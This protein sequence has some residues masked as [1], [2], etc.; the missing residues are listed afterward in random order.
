MVSLR[1]SVWILFLFLCPC[2]EASSA[3]ETV[4]AVQQLIEQGDLKGA[5]NQLTRAL[6]QYPAE[7]GLHNLLGVAEAQLGNYQLAESSFLRAIQLAPGASGTYLNLGRLYQ[8]NSTR[9]GQAPRKALETYRGLLKYHP[10]DVEGNYQCA[11]LLQQQGDL[12]A[13]LDHLA[14]LSAAD[15]QRAQALAVRCADYAALGDFS[16]AT[17]AASRLLASPELSEPD[18]LAILPTIEARQSKESADLQLRLV[19]GLVD[20]RL[21]SA[22][23]LHKL[24]FLY[25]NRERLDQA[26]QTLERVAALSGPTPDLLLQL[27]RLAHKQRDYQGALGYLAHARDLKPD[28]AGIHFFFGM[29]CVQLN[30]GAEAYESLSRAVSLEPKNAYYNY[31]MGAVSLQRRGA[32]E[33]IP[34]F[35][36]YCDLNPEDPR[37]GLMLGI[38]FLESADLESARKELEE[39][40]RHHE[41]VVGAHFYLARLARQEG[42]LPE[43]L[44]AV[45]KALAAHPDHA[46]AYAELGL[47]RF[48]LREYGPAEKALLRAL[49]VDPDNYSG[50]FNLLML[51]R[52]IG[53]RRAEAQARRFEEVKNKRMQKAQDFLRQ[54]E[55]RPYE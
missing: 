2:A 10:T 51:Y 39:A 3:A 23:A 47:I 31:A 52:R 46:D 42:K 49:E 37:G 48:R 4:R 53:D 50:N 7:P 38:A 12:R 35:R 33:A 25:E 30:L 14:R 55:I 13:S 32:S 19:E 20:R 17:E 11:L 43:A 24:A 29:V 28:E 16:Q 45:E 8:E 34:Y 27:A 22:P 9:D 40:A 26:R 36:K 18:V 15:Q 54:I 5:R 44:Q 21:A 1:I 6:K 41:T